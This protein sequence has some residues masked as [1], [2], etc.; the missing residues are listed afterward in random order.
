MGE[1]KRRGTFEERKAAATPKG[2]KPDPQ[3]KPMLVYRNKALDY[4]WGMFRVFGDTTINDVRQQAL[5]AQADA[6]A[7]KEAPSAV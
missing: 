3:Y 5:K 4:L 2:P 6:R 1:A 7:A